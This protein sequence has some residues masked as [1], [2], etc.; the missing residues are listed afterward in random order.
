M[1]V[2][3]SA[4][5]LVTTAATICSTLRKYGSN[6]K[7]ARSDINV[8]YNE[9]A[10]LQNVLE[11]TVQLVNNPNASK[12]STLALL[13][14]NDGP[15]EKCATRLVEIQSKLHPQGMSKT[16]WRAL[17]WPFKSA[18][19]KETVG[20]LERYKS[21]FMLALSAD[22]ATMTVSIDSGIISLREDFAM[23]R[24]DDAEEKKR[25]KLEVVRREAIGWLST[26]DPSINHLEQRRKHEPTTG[27]W[28]VQ[29]RDLSDWRETPNS[30]VW[31]HGTSGCGKTVLSSTIIEHIKDD[32]LQ[33]ECALMYYYFDFNDPKKR[34]VDSFVTS[35]VSQLCCQLSFLPDRLKDLWLE[36]HEGRQRP[37]LV[38]LMRELNCLLADF[39]DVFL[40]VDA[41]D[42]CPE[43]NGERGTL[44]EIITEIHSWQ[45]EHLH[46]LATSRQQT[47]IEV[48]LEPL[49]TAKAISIR[50]EQVNADVKILVSHEVGTIA[51]K[52][53]W[54]PILKTEV[55][56]ALVLGSNGMY[57]SPISF[58]I[59][60][61]SVMIQGLM[62]SY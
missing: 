46:I 62:F 50:D 4:I 49:L 54:P 58:S 44:L 60:F 52:N 23:A 12:F 22:Q 8:L 57:L 26:T 11:K 56:E 7:D 61:A 51:R 2:A 36:C 9:I 18:K 1:D 34:K 16:G 21:A 25:D 53:R 39:T 48:M 31:L 20:E 43:D 10:A 6:V 30:F 41:L 28:F 32:Y 40:V 35:L 24:L 15:A 47:D 55:E 27:D 29:G 14:E 13:N 33:P 3:T 19:V 37:L 17:S 59:F 45:T 38:K 5:S 42:E